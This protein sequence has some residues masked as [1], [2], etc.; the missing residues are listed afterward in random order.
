MIT[1]N[2]MSAAGSN[3]AELVGACLRGNRDAFGQIVARY[4]SLVCSL[5][6]S[7]TG[8]L[9]QSED[10][11]QETFIAAWKHLRQLRE[12]AKLRVWL[13]GIARNRINNS[14]RREGRE[15]SRTA[16]PLD[17]VH[18]LPSPEPLPPDHAISREEESILWRSLERIPE[19]YREPLVLFY[20]EHQSI[21]SVA[22]QLDLSEDAVKQR[23]SRGRKLLHEQ[24]LAFVEGALERIAPGKAFTLGVLAALPVFATSA[25]AATVA[26]AAAKGSATA[27]GAT[28]VTVFNALFGPVVGI[29]GAYFGVR[30]SLDSTRTPRERQF[31]VRQTKF[32]VAWM[33]L[34]NAAVAAYILAAVNSWSTNPV[35]FTILGISLPLLLT[36]SILVMALRYNR[37]YRRIREEEKQHHPELFQDEISVTMSSFKD[38]RSKWT[39]LGL[40][41]VHIRTGAR[42]GERMGTARGWIAIGDRAYGI[43]FAAGAVAVGAISF[44]GAAV[45]LVAIGGACFGLLAIGGFALG[46]LA[47]GG[48]A[49]GIVAAGGAATAWIGAEGGLAVAREFALG[50]QALAQHANDAAA[51]E[52]FAQY[53]WM[54]MTK[55]GNRSWF[56]TLCWLPMLLVIWQGVKARRK[57]KGP[58]SRPTNQSSH[59][60][61]WLA[62]L[63]FALLGTG[64]GKSSGNTSAVSSLVLANGIR[65]VSVSFPGSTNVSIFTFLPMG[66]VTDG[67]D[68]AQWTHLIEHLVI[69]STV[70]TNSREA[71]A[72]TL[73]DHMRLDFYGNLGNWKEGLSHHRRWL[74]G[75]P[76]TEANLAA[77]KPKVMAECDFTA[78]NFTTHKFAA[79]AWSQGYRHG[80]QHVALKGDVT[81]ASLSAVQKLRDERFAVS[82]E[83]TVC[84]VGGLE[85][86]EVFVEVEKQLG[87]AQLPG[88]L[89]PALKARPG[90]LDLTWDL[91]A[92]HLLLTW[93]IPDFRQEDHAALM[94]TAQLLNMALPSDSQL[95]GQTGMTFAGADLA[96]PEGSYF[97]V[98]AS[99]RPGS[100]F[101]EVRKAIHAHVARIA[102]DAGELSQSALIGRQLAIS[103]TELPSVEM[104][105]AQAPPG[106]SLAMIEG[107]MG[108]QLGMHEHRYGAQR[109]ILMKQLSSVT[110]GEV[111]QTVR[112]YLAQEKSSVCTLAATTF[113]ASKK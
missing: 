62:L 96:T 68:Q 104:I 45:G 54:D 98:S 52:F 112:A 78:R 23:L 80:K 8:S 109:V 32:M 99:L 95:P 70:P 63:S 2:N 20:C 111:Q 35:L 5:A 29:L 34:F 47:M 76:F 77:E 69:R 40:P 16:E 30:A 26:T 113:P 101:D 3:D 58:A 84:V 105:K 4:Q 94:V 25:S 87:T 6:Y 36:G 9:G 48:G 82:N 21:G 93:P 44:G 92:R 51:R 38:Y 75:V 22:E 83:V 12:P 18:E 55:A 11:A 74:E 102:S 53:P 89:S 73:P 24:V 37:E 39:L 19:T 60:L 110:A 61:L 50:G 79:A 43:L 31:V 13:C 91:D 85:S 66:L 7:A 100:N 106:V 59:L 97:Y 1:L 107:N 33:M 67:P 10:L 57:R 103:L 108:L 65:V 81:R 56:V 17:T 86:K 90:N 49:I 28:I 64:C 72:E 71:N 42:P 88:A 27:A 14:F 15:T 41:L 46:G